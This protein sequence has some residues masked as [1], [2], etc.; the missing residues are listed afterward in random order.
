MI[1]V[2]RAATACF[3][4]YRPQKLPWGREEESADCLRLKAALYEQVLLAYGFGYRAFISGMAPGVDLYAA[5]AVLKLKQTH[6]D[7]SLYCALPYPTFCA[8]GPEGLR[9]RYERAL[10]GAAGVKVCAE[11]YHAGAMMAR[12]AYMVNESSLLIAV[13]DG[14]PGG[15]QNTVRYAKERGLDI[16]LVP[17][18]GGRMA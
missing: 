14:K 2:E 8:R 4:G 13:Y 1:P 3:T 12:N 10:L 7:A 17:P 18:G 16:W 9:R 15:T 5:E 11:E 6:E